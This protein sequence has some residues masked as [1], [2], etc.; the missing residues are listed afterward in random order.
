M[1]GTTLRV[2]LVEDSADDA[3][4]ILRNLRKGGY[5]PVARRVQSAEEMAAALA[6]QAWDLVLSDYSMP[7]F[8]GSAALAVLVRSGQ[9]LPFIVVSGSI[10]EDTAV[11]MMKAGAHDFVLK[12]NLGR[13]VPAVE[14]ELRDA[15]NRQKRRLTEQANEGLR[16]EREA[17]LE[18]LRRENEDLNALTRIAANAVSSLNVDELLHTL[19]ARVVEV[20]GAD[21]ATILFEEGGELRVRAGEGAVNLGDSTHVRAVGQGFS[22]TVASLL[23]AIYV[24][25]IA[26]TPYLTDPLIRQRGL[27]SLLG[28]PLKRNG[29]LIGVL[30]TGWL[31]PRPRRERDVHM[32]EI[33][34]ERCAAAI[35][36]ARLYEQVVRGAAALARSEASLRELASAVEQ[37]ADSV[38]ITDRHGRIEYVNAAFETIYGYSAAQVIG[39]T[40][41]LLK[42]GEHPAEFFATLWRTVVSGEAFRAV[43]INRHRSG[44]LV[45]QETTITPVR[46]PGGEIARFVATGKDVTEDRLRTQALKVSEARFRAILAAEPE[47]VKVVGPSGRL[48]E[49]NPAGLV[50]LE[51]DTVDEVRARP[52]ADF[53]VP[54][55]RDAFN[56]LFETVIGGGSGRLEFQIVGLRGTRRWLETYA[57]PLQEGAEDRNMLAITRDISETKRTEA[58]L[59]SSLREKEALLKEV[60][61]RVKNNLQ[62]VAS[63]LR[64]EGRRVDDPSTVSVLDQMQGRIQSMALLHEALYRSG[65]FARVDLASYIRQL[66]SQI[67]R[68]ASARVG[69]VALRLELASVMVDIDQAI[70]CGLIVNELASNSLKH[71][72]PEGRTGELRIRLSHPPSGSPL[73]LSVS[74]D[75]V[76]LPRDFEARRARSLGVQLVSDLARQLQGDLTIGPGPGAMFEVRFLNA[77]AATVEIPSGIAGPP[78]G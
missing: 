38:V 24:E 21:S 76:G 29:T 40:P 50:M 34:A 72:F 46:G 54:Q 47:C 27:R 17:L 36:N 30:Q 74:D 5:A 68:S 70:P 44:R 31:T 2:L 60:H 14:R 23:K 61:H 42:S 51:A 18:Q 16:V 15:D 3:D 41:S 43:L 37:T 53:V 33:T 4:L 35:Q 32:L 9:D 25:D 39:Q 55:D 6:E 45:H 73:V 78:R 11:G 75:G 69:S 1:E 65:D 56:R 77:R 71:G 7:G 20:M 12:Q 59:R 63:L 22:G 67:M 57:T 28:V 26:S 48:L 10:G 64:L 13:L 49:M 58:A 52:L 19:L 62:V 66:T 8:D